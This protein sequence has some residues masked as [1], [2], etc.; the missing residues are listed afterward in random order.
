M[1]PP[2]EQSIYVFGKRAKR[3]KHYQGVQIR[4]GAVR[5]YIYIYIYTYIYINTIADFLSHRK[6]IAQKRNL[7]RISR[8][9]PNRLDDVKYHLPT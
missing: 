2:V 9:L 4:A 3:A 5:I 6:C 8:V 1:C 7:S